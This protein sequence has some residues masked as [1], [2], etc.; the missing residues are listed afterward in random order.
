MQRR[1]SISEMQE[2]EREKTR[3]IERKSKCASVNIGAG[4]AAGRARLREDGGRKIIESGEVNGIER[5]E[6]NRGEKWVGPI[7]VSQVHIFSLST[8]L[9]IVS[10]YSSN[11]ASS[12]ICLAGY[13]SSELQH[14]VVPSIGASC[15]NLHQEYTIDDSSTDGI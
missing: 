9:R 1:I 11:N 10:S 13:A 8:I 15:C 6:E 2:R 4:L 5:G 14:H 3:E 12:L 7:E